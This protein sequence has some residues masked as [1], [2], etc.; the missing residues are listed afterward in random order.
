M[1]AFLNQ[2]VFEP[3]L[4]PNCNI[5]KFPNPFFNSKEYLWLHMTMNDWILR[6]NNFR[7]PFFFFPRLH[8]I[9]HIKSWYIS[10]KIIGIHST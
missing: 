10:H 2:T 9:F 4:L 8:S 7:T 3:V 6:S 1:I 5:K